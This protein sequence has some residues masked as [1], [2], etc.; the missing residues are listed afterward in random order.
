M[1]ATA[2]N[3]CATGLAFLI[4]HFGFSEA[5]IVVVYL[6]SVLV[7]SCVTRGYLYGILASVLAILSFNFFFSQPVYSFDVEDINYLFTFLVM[8]LAAVITSKLT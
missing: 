1:L 4:G 5:N 8:L 6:L 2:F 3:L 7:T